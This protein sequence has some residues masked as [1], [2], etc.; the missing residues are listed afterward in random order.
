MKQVKLVEMPTGEKAPPQMVYYELIWMC[1]CCWSFSLLMC[2]AS[3]SIVIKRWFNVRWSTPCTSCFPTSARSLSAEQQ[4]PCR[5]YGS[6]RGFVAQ[7]MIPADLQKN[8]IC[9]P[10]VASSSSSLVST[11]PFII[12]DVL[13][14]AHAPSSEKI[15]RSVWQN[16]TVNFMSTPNGILHIFYLAWSL[17]HSEIS[18]DNLLYQACWSGESS[19]KLV[20]LSFIS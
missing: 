20:T 2:C 15:G 6:E 8:C 18:I 1:I 19:M 17:V 7:V 4:M 14:L 13:P 10:D 3:F 9:A 16:S 5:K 11:T 12:L